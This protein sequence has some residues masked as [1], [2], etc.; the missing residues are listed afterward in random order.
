MAS[1]RGDVVI[2]TN[3]PSRIFSLSAPRLDED[4]WPLQA[5]VTSPQA[6]D[7][8][9]QHWA[10]YRRLL[11]CNY[12]E[13]RQVAEAVGRELEAWLAQ[14]PAAAAAPDLVDLGCGDLALLPPLLRRLPLASY[15]GLDLTPAVLPLAREALGPVAYS[16]QWVEGDLLAWATGA[17]SGVGC[18]DILHAGFAIHHLSDGEKA[19]FLQG[20][21]QRIRPGGVFLWADVFR[22][23]GESRSAYIQRFSDRVRQRWHQLDAG[24]RESTLAHI[25]G[26]DHPADRA[27]IR[28]A[29][30]AAG[31]HWRW[32]WQG[33]HRAEAMAVLTPAT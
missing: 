19:R 26:F 31:W 23:P 15:M 8:F 27:E 3:Q 6:T 16:T 29:A 21:R 1:D 32:A 22:E 33:Q 9:L 2:K 11:G 14:R 18:T 7:L 13:H 4:G 25:S 28:A 30:E 24:Q 12:M 10:T 5:G 17:G 20:A